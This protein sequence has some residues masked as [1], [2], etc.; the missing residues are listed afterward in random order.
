MGDHTEVISIDY[1]PTLLSYEQLLDRFWGSHRCQSINRSRQYMNA[2]F[3]RDEEQR[4]AAE[5]SLQQ[6]ANKLGIDNKR[7]KTEILPVKTFTYAETYHQKYYLTRYPEIRDALT[8]IYP[9]GKSLA[10]STV[11]TRLNAYLGS[12]IQPD[13]VQFLENLPLYGLPEKVTAKLE[14]LAKRKTNN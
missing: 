14:A 8:E 3:Y 2:V 12:G 4:L 11:A 10:D 7:V 6:Q 13:W 5:K 9:D 1:D